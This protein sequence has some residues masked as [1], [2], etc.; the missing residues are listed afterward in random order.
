VYFSRK[1]L[2][3][4]A[5]EYFI[6]KKTLK[7][8]VQGKKVSKPIVSISI[9]SIA[10]AVIVNLITVAVVTGFQQEVR[11]KVS[12]FGS[13]IFI[14]AAGENS[15]Y[16]S[17]PVRRDQ[18]FISALRKDPGI[19]S[20]H[21]VGYK[22]VLFQS[23]ERE[24]SYTLPNGRDTTEHQY[25][26][27]GAVIKGVDTTFD[28]NF[29]KKHLLEGEIPDYSQDS[30]ENLL[31]ISK[32][33]A[34]DLNYKIG[35]KISA[36]FVKNLPVKRKFTISAIY[37]TGLEEFDKQIVLGKLS[38]VQ[39]LNDWG[40]DATI[41]IADTLIDDQIVIKANASGGNGNLRYDWGEGF[42]SY[43]G[44]SICP[45][46]DTIVRLIV[47]DYWSNISADL[48]ESTLADTAYLKITV[49]GDRTARCNFKLNDIDEL[50]REYL[51]EEGTKF[52]L[53]DG[54][55]RVICE[56]TPGK[57]SHSNY[58]GGFEITVKE[59]SDLEEVM[60]RV[61]RKVDNQLTVHDEVLKTTSI[62]QNQ[63]D[64]FMWLGFLDLNVIII[65][66]LMILI[67]IINMG[68]ALLVL[69]L[70]RTNFIGMMKAM[71][72]TNTSIRKIF[73]YQAGFLIGR[74]MLWGN[75]IGLGLCLIQQYTGFISLNPEVYYLS[76]VPIE[77]NIW[78]WLIL[79]AAT[80][81]VCLSA[82]IIPSM[83]ITSIHPVKAIK[84]N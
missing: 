20:I 27:H 48:S 77:L 35:D 33:L 1:A 17:A 15:I 71:G 4:L 50:D 72:A 63:P 41:E 78:H 49:E 82:L 54:V 10:L 21:V 3:N 38:T 66:T 44:F 59:W 9:I 74:G 83:V 22:P 34:S 69:I 2:C 60:T 5:F 7:S 46:R 45:D 42:D 51:N 14:M 58:V 24:V 30:S 81:V 13:H 53:S 70:I 65:L 32:R 47:T 8:V 62:I 73:L 31:V 23:D 28:W 11:Q 67:G 18:E 75:L 80:L 40:I 39:Q 29:F 56:I 19:Q 43:Y 37:K 76:E 16:E 84:F 52:A 36:F 12:G 6:S 64:I 68:S 57:G 55:K 26:V 61:K 79:N 25:Q